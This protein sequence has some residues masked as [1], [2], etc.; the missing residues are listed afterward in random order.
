MITQFTF[1]ILQKGQ[2]NKFELRGFLNSVSLKKKQLV[3]P[4][5]VKDHREER[6]QTASIPDVSVVPLE[7]STSQVLELIELGIS[8]IIIFG[9]PAERDAV[10]SH[11]SDHNGIVQKTVRKLKTEFGNALNIITDVCLCQYNLSGHCGLFAGQSGLVD[12][13]G[14]VRALC[15]VAVS[16]AQAGADVVSPSSMMDGQV[17]SI[18][19]SLDDHG[20][21]KIRILSSSAKHFSSLYTPFRSVAF[22]KQI[23]DY[24]SLDKSSYQVPY[25]NLRE[26]V[27]EIEN[28]VR[29]GADMVIVKPA[30]MYLDVISMI[31]E[32]LSFPIAVQNVS[33]EY[34]MIKYAAAN[35]WINEEEWKIVSICAMKRAGADIII[36]YFCKDIAAI[37]NC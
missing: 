8:S 13:D 19:S 31:K 1:R 16:H 34:A 21:D 15:E 6:C 14:T 27:R 18:R 11:A 22:S 9:V 26:S 12:N 4:L 30:I 29:E 24:K 2:C 37:L 10:G 33:G 7:R 3:C 35:N 32:K 20:Y 5:F 36:S 17:S 28:D 23:G 25:T